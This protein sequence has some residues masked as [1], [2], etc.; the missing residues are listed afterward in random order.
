MYYARG[1]TEKKNMQVC[2][3]TNEN[4]EIN[5]TVRKEWKG[6]KKVK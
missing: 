5:T 6:R 2:E 3:Y 1:E 4:E